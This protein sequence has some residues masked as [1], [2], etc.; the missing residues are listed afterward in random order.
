MKTHFPR[1][2]L[3]PTAPVWA[4]VLLAFTHATVLAAAS[5]V[6]Q[7]IVVFKTHFDLGYTDMASNVVHRYRTSMIDAALEV[8]DLNA[9]L[10]P[11]Q[12]FVWTLPGWPMAKIAGDWPGQTSTRQARV[13]Q[14]LR[15]GRFAVHGLPFTMHTELL[16]LEDLVRGLGYSTTLAHR[17]GWALPRDAKMTDVPCHSWILPTLLRHAGIQFLHLGCNPASRSPELP[18]LFWW[19]GADGSRLLTMYTAE[20]Y[21]TDLVPPAG[22]SHR[23]WLALI[24]TGD[25][26]GPPTPEEITHLRDRARREL[27]GVSVR[28]GRLSDFADALLAENPTLPV[29]RGDMPDT[30]IH[31]PM[32]DPEGARI[33]RQ[34]RPRIAAAET[35][36][37]QGRAWGLP[38]DR[39]EAILAEARERSLLY[40]EHT[41]GGALYWVSPYSGGRTLEYGDA[42]KSAWLQGKFQQLEASWDEHSGYIKAAEQLIT[43]ALQHTLDSLAAA[44]RVEGRRFVVYNPLP[45]PRDGLVTIEDPLWPESRV[46]PLEGGKPQELARSPSRQTVSFVAGAVPPLGYRTYVP[47]ASANQPDRAS[48]SG[49]FRIA[50]GQI[51]SPFFR[52][53]FDTN[54]GVIRSLVDKRTNREWVDAEAPHGF[55]SYLYER[56][57]ACQVQEYVQAYVKIDAAWATNELGK[58]SMPSAD[59]APYRAASP[60]PFTWQVHPQPSAVVVEMRSPPST[61]IPHWVTTRLTLH[62]ELPVADLEIELEAKPADPWP[63]AG[64]LCL[65]FRL[66]EPQ[67]ALGRLGSIVDPNRDF[68]PGANHHLYALELGMAILDARR[69]GV[70]LC[71]LDN[72]LVSLDEPGCW[73]YSSTYYPRRAHVYVNLFN[74]QWT[75]NFRLWNQGTWTARVRLWSIEKYDPAKDLV[76]PSLEARLPLL[77]AAS[78]AGAGRLPGSQPG[79]ALSHPG[80]RLTAFGPNPEGEGWLLRL[81]E[82]SGTA[83]RC[84][85]TL[86]ATL[87]ASFAQPVNLRGVAEGA[88]VPIH[89]RTFSVPL[90]PFAPVSLL[91]RPEARPVKTDDRIRS[92]SQSS[93][94]ER[95]ALAQRI[96]NDPA[97]PDV[98]QRAK[99]LLRTGFNAGSGYQEVW[100]RDLA[101]FIELSC[102]VVDVRA[103]RQTLLMFFRLQGEDGNIVD[104]FIPRHQAN[105]GYDYIKRASVPDFWGHKNTVETDQ[106]SS[107]VQAVRLYVR[108]TGDTAF[109]REMIDGQT[110]LQRLERALQYLLDHRFSSPH[111][112]LWGATTADWGDVQPEHEWGVVLDANSHR[113]IDVYD[114]AM[115][116]LALSD[117]AALSG[118]NSE[119][120]RHWL[121]L[122][123]RVKVSLRRYLWDRAR[124]KFRPHLYLNGSPFPPELDEDQIHYH[125]GTAVAILAGVLEPSEISEVLAHMRANVAAAGADSIGLTVYPPYP[126]G[127]FKN[128]SMGPYSY[129]NGGDWDWFG[130]RMIQ[131]LIQEDR[132]EEAYTELK[133]MLRR[134][135]QH[136]GF[137]EWWDRAGQPRGSATFRGSAGVLGKAILML[138]EWARRNA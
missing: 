56:F 51:E 83:G 86:P 54:R 89:R 29:V 113:A 4:A 84:Q 124:G 1:R 90:A 138:Q 107:L 34:V 78:K 123:E 33:A 74:N 134:I 110:V 92:N 13:Q 75:T 31:G 10:P 26:H 37:L 70:G 127:S 72:P 38:L 119:S 102:Q 47:V 132:V 14:A 109:L 122:H 19:E 7:V 65:P 95:A 136:Q 43:P 116:L 128:R 35:L 63:E 129:Q 130:G 59:E 15:D 50:P 100:I 42:W 105:A 87:A 66:A 64:W 96:L 137:Y 79:L 135:R 115:F 82:S 121:N 98:L 103:I 91:L 20:S 52:V 77:A 111:S 49:P 120:A 126:A 46:R 114:N 106:E 18:R 73:R 6:D 71:A 68:V 2:L 97:L 45:Y 23:T 104:G 17:G 41:W 27:P 118:L 3:V 67:F 69:G 88:P 55:G 39:I 125:G 48:R 25:N 36:N 61:G 62:R 11:E 93:R 80:A 57:D 30:W 131:A 112:L 133:P 76:R 12:R 22:W 44:V 8:V 108:A 21:G 85:V 53:Q 40:G 5:A 24:H 94:K 28:I 117:L 32:C 16:E 99:A 60:G 101:T 9:A 81:W 58:P